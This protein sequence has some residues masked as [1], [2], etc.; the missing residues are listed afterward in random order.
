MEGEEKGKGE[1]GEGGGRVGPPQVKAWPPITIFLAPALACRHFILTK[2]NIVGCKMSRL[3]VFLVS[4]NSLVMLYCV[5]VEQLKW[6][7]SEA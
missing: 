3:F 1:E 4:F 2:T 6:R 7:T 5:F